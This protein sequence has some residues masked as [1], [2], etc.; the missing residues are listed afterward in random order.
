M[1]AVI[2]FLPTREIG[3]DFTHFPERFE[4]FRTRRDRHLF[5]EPPPGGFPVHLLKPALPYDPA[6]LT[7]PLIGP[8]PSAPK[9]GRRA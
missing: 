5:P 3:E 4:L 2:T 7:L 9:Q 6:Q 1:L 8:A